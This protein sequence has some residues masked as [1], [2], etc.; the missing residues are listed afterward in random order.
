MLAN[1]GMDDLNNSNNIDD[2]QEEDDGITA[3]GI[4][5][6][7]VIGMAAGIGAFMFGAEAGLA[8]PNSL[9]AG[10]ICSAVVGLSA[11]IAGFMLGKAV[12]K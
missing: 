6:C 5:C 12:L 11:G 7:G 4:I 3:F 9:V 1:N 10:V 2:I 8:G